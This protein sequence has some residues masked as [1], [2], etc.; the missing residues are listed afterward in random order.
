VVIK[1]GSGDL[2]D[3]L[4][5]GQTAARV[6]SPRV[7][8]RY[9]CYSRT[10]IINTTIRLCTVGPERMHARNRDAPTCRWCLKAYRTGTEPFQVKSCL[11]QSCLGVRA[12]DR[13]AIV[14][15]IGTAASFCNIPQIIDHSTLG[16]SS[17]VDGYTR[18]HYIWTSTT[19]GLR[20]CRNT[21]AAVRAHMMRDRKLSNGS[22]SS[23]SPRS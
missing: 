9:N 23:Q 12:A 1:L 16:T 18:S 20:I 17:P 5:C 11:K 19:S 13:C 14:W 8:R 7:M 6:W 22:R 15:Q 4:Q 21:R 2:D 3:G 10:T